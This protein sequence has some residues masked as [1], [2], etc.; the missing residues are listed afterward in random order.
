METIVEKYQ[1]QLLEQ[2]QSIYYEDSISERTKKAYLTTPRH[3]FVKRFRNWGTKEW[4]EINEENLE[5]H[6]AMLYANRPLI[7][8]GDDD[9][10]VRSTIS[11]PTFVLRMLDML[12]VEPDH[13]VLELGAGSGWN[14]ALMGHLVGPEGLVYSLEIIPEIAKI[15]AETIEQLAIENVHIIEADG[16][17]G[18]AAGG[19][20][21][22]AIF[23]AGAYDLP[24]H[25]FEQMK[26]DGLLLIVIK[27]EGGG[28]A[29]FLLR[30]RASHFESIEAQQ[31]GF[32]QMK[33]KY[34]LDSL[35]PINL[36]ALPEWSMLKD[37]AIGTR[38]FW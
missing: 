37:Q 32:V 7:L 19:P 9:N 23:T 33:G 1:N 30:K 24:H 16:G 20:Y 38:P 2:A 4:H 25:F 31:C 6:I 22:R 13:K 21:D 27:N 15:A 11:Q 26:D 36:E 10:D 28:D 14:A 3:L 34:Q 12:Q 8:F 18:Y 29:L 35:E 17:E 5:E